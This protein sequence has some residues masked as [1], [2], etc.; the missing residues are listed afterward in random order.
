MIIGNITIND[1]DN[2]GNQ[3]QLY[4]IQ[5]VL[6]KYGQVENVDWKE[7]VGANYRKRGLTHKVKQF[8]KACIKIVIFPYLRID[9]GYIRYKNFYK[10]NKEFIVTHKRKLNNKR[11]ESKINEYFDFFVAGSDQIWNPT[12][13]N[14]Q[15]YINMLGFTNAEKRIALSPSVSIDELTN[16]QEQEFK[17]YLTD[18]K[19][20]SCREQQGAGLLEAVVGK[21]VEALLDPT[22]M[23]SA[24]DWSKIALKPQFHNEN[25][26]YILI[27][28]LGELTNV[29]KY[30]I[31]I[32]A[33]EN[34]LEIIN[35]MDMKSKY[36]TCGPREFV[37]L[38]KNCKLM[39]TDSFHG[40]VFS[41]IF[42]KSFKIFK[43]K[44]NVKS[45]NS[46]LVN[47]I[48]K[49]NLDKSIYYEEGQS[50]DNIFNTNYDKSF[51][52]TE[53]EGTESISFG[54]NIKL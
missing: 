30:I 37:Y 17:K 4:A 24:E 48:E 21:P 11:N 16:E 46:R 14:N 25:K 38:I 41:Y 20:L 10:F 31:N 3:L 22:L 42:D 19:Y 8:I 9:K 34:N 54:V 40:S 5:Q 12:F 50:L 29:Y 18:Y 26:Q 35:L 2:Y 53:L 39:I 47:L 36:Y 44:D 27:Y 7:C 51:L 13:F 49:L 43:R 28:F 32:I 52:N 1:L 6:K 15:M 23:L 45:M 33:Q